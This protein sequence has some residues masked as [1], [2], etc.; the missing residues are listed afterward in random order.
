VN[1]THAEA[2]RLLLRIAPNRTAAPLGVP[3]ARNGDGWTWAVDF[4]RDL[5]LLPAL[6]HLLSLAGFRAAASPVAAPEGHAAAA[7]GPVAAPEGQK[8][9]AGRSSAT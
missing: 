5:L 3:V 1:V 8:A 9:P 7:G 2:V 6:G 4:G